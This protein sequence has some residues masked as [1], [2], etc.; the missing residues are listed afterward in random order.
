M[1]V[2]AKHGI[3]VAVGTAVVAAAVAC[4]GNGD[5]PYGNGPGDGFGS[6]GSGP[7]GYGYR[8]DAGQGG[9][10]KH[11]GGTD[12][13]SHGGGDSG[14]EDLD[15]GSSGGGGHDAQGG[16]PGD[17][18]TDDGGGSSVG[19]TFHFPPGFFPSLN[20]VV[21]GP[22]GYYSGIVYFGDAQSVEFVAGGITAGSGYTITMAG[23]DHDG[24]PCSGTSAPFT[25]VPGQV[26]GASLI[27]TCTVPQFDASEPADVVTGSVGVEAGVMLPDF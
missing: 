17:A 18:Q 14:P 6:V 11:D 4:G 2:V 23:N 5:N 24:D 19:V 25:I 10:G 9:G 1:R 15:S 12:A 8:P 26:A 16:G 13:G 20:W 7:G 27:L 3:R 22:S 21:S